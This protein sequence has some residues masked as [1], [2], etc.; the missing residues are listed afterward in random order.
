MEVDDVA[1]IVDLSQWIRLGGQE[2][3]MS[4]APT[5]APAG[6][7]HRAPASTAA[8]ATTRTTTITATART[9]RDRYDAPTTTAATAAATATATATA[10][11]VDL[12]MQ[13]GVQQHAARKRQRVKSKLK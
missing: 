10:V 2:D 4:V 12:D 8:A 7:H 6:P 11:A 9:K 13:D 1:C 3:V 5:A